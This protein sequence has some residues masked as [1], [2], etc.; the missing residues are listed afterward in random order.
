MKK[1]GI[2]ICNYNKAEMVVN[3]IQYIFE[4]TFTD[5][6]VYVVDNAST[7]NSVEAIKSTYG[8]RVTLLVN[9]ENLGGTGGF[10]TGLRAA[11]EKGYDYL[12]CVDNDAYLDEKAIEELYNFLEAHQEAGMA[13]SKVYHLEEPGRIQQYGQEINF[14]D[15]CTNVPDI[16]VYDDGSMPD[17][18]YVDAAAACALMVRRSTIE[19]IGFMSEEFFLYWDDTDWCWR[20][21]LAGM[22]V[23]SVGSSLALHQMG[24]KNERVNTFPTYYAWRNWIRFFIKYSDRQ[25]FEMMAR[26]FL[27]AIFSI[28]YA[29]FH[30]GEF[31]QT[32]TVMLAYEDAI[33]GITGKAGDNRIFPID[34]NY[35]PFRKLFSTWDRFYIEEGEYPGLAASIR[36]TAQKVGA[37]V[38]FEDAPGQGI[39]TIKLC[40]TIFKVEDMSLE[41]VYIDLDMCVF[42][43]RDEALSIINYDYS[44]RMFVQTQLPVFLEFANELKDSL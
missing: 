33:H 8:D 11:F 10:N 13:A 42:S 44:N 17:F 16:N 18:K 35:E 41:N 27:N 6:D 36:S 30:K 5:F 19:K 43:N 32:K 39:K 40:E 20:C 3:C 15:F 12:M 26:T 1:L 29:D 34:Y 31:N 2:V 7:D 4:N 21:W 37:Q 28:V 25:D 24:A 14:T 9:D 38:S 23:A 22:K